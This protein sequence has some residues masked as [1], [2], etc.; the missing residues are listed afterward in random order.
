MAG[1][2][3]GGPAVC[4]ALSPVHPGLP[5]CSALAMPQGYQGD[6]KKQQVPTHVGSWW[7]LGCLGLVSWSRRLSPPFTAHPAVR[8]VVSC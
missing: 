6:K 3:C 4:W 7:V 5:G 1:A 2:S 8:P